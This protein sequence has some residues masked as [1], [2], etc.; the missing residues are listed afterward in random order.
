MSLALRLLLCCQSHAKTSIHSHLPCTAKHFELQQDS[1]GKLLCIKLLSWP[2]V[3]GALGS[4]R[5]FNT[6]GQ[7]GSCW[8]PCSA[9]HD[10]LQGRFD[11]RS[12]THAAAAPAYFPAAQGTVNDSHQL[13]DMCCYLTTVVLSLLLVPA[14]QC[15]ALRVAG[16]LR[17]PG[18]HFC[19]LCAHPSSARLYR[20]LHRW[21]CS[22]HGGGHTPCRG[23]SVAVAAESE[24]GCGRRQ[25]WAAGG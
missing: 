16:G 24:R 12:C 13:L 10:K 20:R 17:H 8:L 21:V 6:M 18:V 15:A 2:T 1:S 23:P 22:S 11:P 7:L 14:P 4:R 19:G 5:H 3:Q 25:L 9:R